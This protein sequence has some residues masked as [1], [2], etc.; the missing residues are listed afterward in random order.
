MAGR[1]R[2]EPNLAAGLS[3]A[4]C[5]FA[6]VERPGPVRPKRRLGLGRTLN[7]EVGALNL[8]RAPI[9]IQQ[10]IC[11]CA[12]RLGRWRLGDTAGRGLMLMGIALVL[13]QLCNIAVQG[14]AI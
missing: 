8:E 11:R 12:N 14:G 5:D 3:A 7:A 2:L 6:D 13:R 4:H 10:R 9:A 1:V